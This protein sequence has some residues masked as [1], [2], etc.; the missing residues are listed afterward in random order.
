MVEAQ[1]ELS[2]MA[3]T[4]VVIRGNRPVTSVGVSPP[5]TPKMLLRCKAVG[6]TLPV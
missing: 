3:L 2:G 5:T 1:A 6:Q 4:K